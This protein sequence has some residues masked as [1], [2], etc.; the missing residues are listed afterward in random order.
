MKDAKGHGSASRGGPQPKATGPSA[1][2]RAA[3]D[4]AAAHAHEW[5]QEPRQPGDQEAA[6]ALSNGPKSAPA[7]VHDAWSSTPGGD[8]LAFNV[9]PKTGPTPEQSAYAQR[10]MHGVNAWG[11]NPKDAAATRKSIREQRSFNSARREINRL[12]KQGK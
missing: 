1:E 4:Y 10:V 2:F 6:N 9:D 5:G 12:R 3:R 7:P 8:R 11:Q